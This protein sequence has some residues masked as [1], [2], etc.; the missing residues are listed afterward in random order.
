M[1]VIKGTKKKELVTRQL[2]LD[3]EV[4][5]MVEAYLKYL[6]EVHGEIITESSVY[7]QAVVR[8]L[9][10]DREFMTRYL[11]TKPRAGR[12]SSGGERVEELLRV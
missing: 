2:K 6:E 12:G 11:G 9:S 3:S 4:V 7:E 10:M 8:V 5:S 1:R